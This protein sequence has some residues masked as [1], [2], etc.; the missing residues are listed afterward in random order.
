MLEITATGVRTIVFV[1]I[2][3]KF[4]TAQKA[5]MWKKCSSWKVTK[6]HTLS[7]ILVCVCVCLCNNCVSMCN[8][9]CVWITKHDFSSPWI[10]FVPCPHNMHTLCALCKHSPPSLTPNMVGGLVLLH[11]SA[12][13][14]H[15][16]PSSSSHKRLT[17][18]FQGRMGAPELF[19]RN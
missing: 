17:E 15:W 1:F 12:N 19:E 8:W 7:C 4:Q 5:E 13:D 9:V 2:H 3:L 10:V 6:G 11:Q 18:G 16:T 14:L